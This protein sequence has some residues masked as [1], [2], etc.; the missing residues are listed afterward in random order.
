MTHRTTRL[1]SIAAAVFF[2]MPVAAWAAQP[3]TASA[4]NEAQAAGKSIVVDVTAPWCPTCA[5]QK[6]IVEGLE[7][8]LPQL[9]VFDVDFDSAKDVLKQFKVQNQSTLIVFKGG[10]EIDR[11][12]GQTDPAVIRAMVNKGL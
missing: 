1:L 10:K 8:D 7:H 6:P 2:T 5:K 9:M 3:F 4:F 12:T 11:S